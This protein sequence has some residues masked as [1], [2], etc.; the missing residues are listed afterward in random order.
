ML[1]K[2]TEANE[3]TYLQIDGE[4]L[5]VVNLKSIRIAKTESITGHQ[6]NIMAG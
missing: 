5:K 3:I 4:S 6:I 2:P 1:F